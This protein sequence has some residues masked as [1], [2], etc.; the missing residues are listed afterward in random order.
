MSKWTKFTAGEDLKEG[1]MVLLN[2]EGLAVKAE[3][4]SES[5]FVMRQKVKVGKEFAYPAD[6]LPQTRPIEGDEESPP[7]IQTDAETTGDK[8]T[9]EA[10]PQEA[11][12]FGADPKLVKTGYVYQGTD[13]KGNCYY[14][15]A[16]GAYTLK[17]SG[18]FTR[19]GNRFDAAFLKTLKWNYHR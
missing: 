11:I 5:T 14:T 16:T 15:N 8:Q 12:L 13:G 7:S 9:S 19:V 17:S 2:E 6:K 3:A 1:D 4:E 18:Q 10:K